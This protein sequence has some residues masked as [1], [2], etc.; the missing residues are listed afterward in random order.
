MFR[1]ARMSYLVL[2]RKYRPRTFTQMVGLDEAERASTWS[3]IEEALR[4]FEGG[5][6]FV[7]PCEMLVG[8]GST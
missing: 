7:G 4:Q 1:I 6:G 2:A 3:A 5:G 8:A